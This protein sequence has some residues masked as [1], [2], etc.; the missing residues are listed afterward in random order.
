[1]DTLAELPRIL[2]QQF[3]IEGH[4]LPVEGIP[5]GLSRWKHCGNPF[6]LMGLKQRAVSGLTNNLLRSLPSS[7]WF[8]LIANLTPDDCAISNSA[9]FFI[10]VWVRSA[11]NPKNAK[12]CNVL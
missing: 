11:L 3:R 1:M 4:E 9:F 5:S 2:W 8:A 10:Q 12:Y 6:E 7:G